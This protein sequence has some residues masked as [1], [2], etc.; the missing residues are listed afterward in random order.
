[1]SAY[2]VVFFKKISVMSSITLF[3]VQWHVASE[4]YIPKTK[5]PN[6]SGVKDFWPVA[7]LN[8]EEKILLA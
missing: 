4:V 7:L 2:Y 5:L 6:P 3:P 1:M 8:A